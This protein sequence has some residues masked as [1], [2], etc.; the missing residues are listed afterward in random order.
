MDD[1]VFLDSEDFDTPEAPVVSDRAEEVMNQVLNAHLHVDPVLHG[2]LLLA[3]ASAV[4]RHEHACRIV[5]S[6]EGELVTMSTKNTLMVHPAVRVARDEAALVEKLSKAL[7]LSPSQEEAAR[8][9]EGA[10]EFEALK[11]LKAELSA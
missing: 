8:E 9:K 1:F 4:V 11:L 3:Y 6:L 2:D 10:N 7:A 5:N